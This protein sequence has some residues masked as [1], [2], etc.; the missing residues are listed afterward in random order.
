[1]YQIDRFFALLSCEIYRLSFSIGRCFRHFW[2]PLGDFQF[3]FLA[4]T[5]GKKKDIG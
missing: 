3:D 4:L 1:M 5:D 2:I